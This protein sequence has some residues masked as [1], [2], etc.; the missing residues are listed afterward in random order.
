MKHKMLERKR[1]LLEEYTIPLDQP[2]VLHAF[3]IP[4]KHDSGNGGEDDGH[5][6]D[7][8]STERAPFGVIILA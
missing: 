7:P 4:D 2:S 5:K 6:N 1:I 8:K 3:G